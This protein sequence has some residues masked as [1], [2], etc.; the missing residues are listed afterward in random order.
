LFAAVLCLCLPAA[1]SAAQSAAQGSITG[2]GTASIKQR[3][4]ILR[5]QVDLSA[6]GKDLKEAL[7]RLKELQASIKPQLVTLGA[8]EASISF[9]DARIQQQR[10]DQ[11]RQME[12]M[13]RARMGGKKPAQPQTPPVAVTC[14]LKAE[15]AIKSGTAEET[16]IFAHELKQKVVALTSKQSKALT[17]EEEER[18]EEEGVSLS[19]YD[20][21]SPK[22]GEPVFVYVRKLA[23]EERAKALAEAYAEAK[24]HARQLAQA[25]G[26]QLGDLLHLTAAAAPDHEQYQYDPY[27]QR[28][29]Y[30]M[31]QRGYTQAM[32]NDEAIGMDPSAVVTTIT[33]TASFQ[34]K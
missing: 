28:M 3:P 19:G 25:A 8:A 24:D 6:E 34:P 31:M 30:A 14:M 29:M 23:A 15:W 27:A 13:M 2:N 16:L 5:L 1:L 22:P 26:I 12:Q 4:D 9:G 21:G 33:V 18:M 7:T 10:D 11:R 20:D 17:P 32:K